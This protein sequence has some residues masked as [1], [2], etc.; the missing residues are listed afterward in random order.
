MTVSEVVTVTELNAHV[1]DVH[2]AGI[3]DKEKSL[4]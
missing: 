1:D 2:L 3:P 4:R